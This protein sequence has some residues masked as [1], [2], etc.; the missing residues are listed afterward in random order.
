M[1]RAAVTDATAAGKLA[2][3][4]SDDGLEA[5][6]LFRPG[7]TV[8]PPTSI[9]VN[10][11][12]QE[13]HIP[14]D[15]AAM[16]RIKEALIEC[17]KGAI[18]RGGVLLMRGQAPGES[19]DEQLKFAGDPEPV[20]RG[21][22]LEFRRVKAGDTIATITPA[23]EGK[24]G[25]DVFGGP[26][27]ARSPLPWSV[28]M[29]SGV[30]LN[31][32][33][34]IQATSEG[35]ALLDERGLRVVP[36]LEMAAAATTE[37]DGARTPGLLLIH[38]DVP[39]GAFL[40]AGAGILIDGKLGPALV[41]TGGSLV[42]TGGIEGQRESTQIDVAGHAWCPH[43]FDSQIN[44]GGNLIVANELHGVDA[45]IAGDLLAPEAQFAEGEIT[46]TGHA[47]LGVLGGP[48][49][50]RTQLTV[51]VH[52][53][54]RK[55]FDRLAQVL[56]KTNQVYG[57]V[58]QA[59]CLSGY[60][61]ADAALREKATQWEMAKWE[62]SQIRTTVQKQIGN[63]GRNMLEYIE[64]TITVE[65]TLYAGTQIGVGS[66]R[67]TIL[68]PWSGPLEISLQTVHQN[69]VLIVEGKSGR[70]MVVR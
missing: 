43:L 1:V 47:H 29:G 32:N 46:V 53:G 35:V 67:G 52:E 28:V 16:A 31:P 51:G 57:A 4:V 24:S 54:L 20:S 58:E 60:R 8:A 45:R 49:D 25:I 59:C 56:T 14:I 34:T 42:C 50:A 33:R 68:A 11:V 36:L 6:L 61:N 15:R 39:A 3:K 30:G 44:V 38:G 23:V 5:Y 70:K 48:S 37:G 26:L 27:P 22:P 40:Q 55:Q 13:N 62:L 12:V 21:T 19:T 63:I 69:T 10:A 7:A 66:T 17:R 9:E 18:P 65:E 41:S 2:V 64:S